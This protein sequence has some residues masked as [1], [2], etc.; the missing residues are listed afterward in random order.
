MH[1]FFYTQQFV[2]SKRVGRTRK[3]RIAVCVDVCGN[4]VDIYG[5]VKFVYTFGKIRKFV[6]DAPELLSYALKLQIYDDNADDKRHDQT[7]YDYPGYM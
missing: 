4:T 7:Y 5:Y 6:I 2:R 1:L 3:T